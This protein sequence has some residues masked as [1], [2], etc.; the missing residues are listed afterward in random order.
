MVADSLT[1]IERRDRA[2]QR[3]RSSGVGSG[4]SAQ[5]ADRGPLAGGVRHV[6]LDRLPQEGRIAVHQ[7]L[8]PLD[9][10]VGR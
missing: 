10:D 5:K 4:G 3:K 6:G 7:G 1:C 2:P 8:I 9:R